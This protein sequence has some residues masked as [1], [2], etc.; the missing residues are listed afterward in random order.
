LSALEVRRAAGAAD[1]ADVDA[2]QRRTFTNAWGADAIRWELENT[3]VARLYVL[4]GRDGALIGYCACW[5]V[6]D[7]LHINSLAIDESWRRRGA[8]RHLLTFVF[9]DAVTAGARSATL[10]VRQ[11]NVA[12]RALYEGLGFRVEGVRRD[13]YQEPREDALILWNRRL[14][15]GRG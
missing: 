6:F 8:A 3:D 4:R 9:D 13:Y 15:D 7:E 2:L 5:M 11:S 10:E 14:A 12:A 1:L